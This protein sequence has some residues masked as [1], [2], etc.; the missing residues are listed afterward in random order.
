MFLYIK[1]A[2][3]IVIVVTKTKQLNSVSS[4]IINKIQELKD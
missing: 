1:S 2:L 4:F 3:I